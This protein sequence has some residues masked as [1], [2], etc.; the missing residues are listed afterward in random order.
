MKKLSGLGIFLLAALFLCLV[1][2]IY[3]TGGQE[4][5]KTSGGG[6]WVPFKDKAEFKAYVVLPELT[7]PQLG[8]I[9]DEM[10]VPAVNRVA[11][12]ILRIG[13]IGGATNPFWDIIKM[14]V[15]AAADEL[16]THNCKV[17]WIV[18]GSTLSSTDSGAIID[19]MLVKHY[20]AITLMIYN[21]G[22]IPYIDKAVAQNVPVAGYCIDTQPN[23]ALFLIGQDLYAS[24]SKCADIMAQLINGKGK[25]A[26]ITGQF[27]VTAHEL[28]RKGFVDRVKAAYPEITIVGQ[29]EAKD[30][31]EL[32]RSQTIDYMTA[33]PDLAGVYCTAGGPIGAGQAIKE[34]GKAGKIKVVAYDPLP[35]TLEF[36][37]DGSIQAVIGQNPYAQGRDTVIRMFNYL[38]EGQLPKARFLYTRA[39]VVTE[40][41]ALLA[42]KK[43]G[44]I[45][46]EQF[47][48]TKQK[49]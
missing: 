10:N 3:A 20:D 28:R 12:K 40:D 47:Y 9:P 14:G 15:D 25:V 34:A 8:D 17:D 32:T 7:K 39:D 19:T 27:N 35:Q 30:Q 37:K 13:V 41:K 49:G 6:D 46:I 31:A 22:L 36:I 48:T 38:M 18:P 43:L 4:A 24:G 26:V 1:V 21:E 2:P 44:A 29:T 5:T 45:T 33:N 42:N 23:K 16:L 11:P